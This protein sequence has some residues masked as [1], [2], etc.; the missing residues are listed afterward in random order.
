MKGKWIGLEETKEH[1][2]SSGEWERG[3]ALRRILA[4]NCLV[5][6]LWNTFLQKSIIGYRCITYA[7]FIS[8]RTTV[9]ASIYYSRWRESRELSVHPR[10]S[11]RLC[12]CVSVRTIELNGWNYNQQTCHMDS[13]LWVLA[14][15][16]ILGQ[17]FKG[18]GHRV[19]K[20][21]SLFQLKAIEWPAWVCTT[22]SSGS[23]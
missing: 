14:T 22:L 11:V 3:S 20:C 17:K 13:P 21:K 4:K 1:G 18:Q 2:G 23:V 6:T 5:W 7:Y 19:T 9:W 10:L 12:V 8:C 15:H 16:L